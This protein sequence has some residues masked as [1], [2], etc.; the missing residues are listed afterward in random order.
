MV[1]PARH[2]GA[3]RRAQDPG[4]RRRRADVHRGP[5]APRARVAAGDLDAHETSV[6][7]GAAQAA[8]DTARPVEARL[9]AMQSPELWGVLG[10]HPLRELVSTEGPYPLY[11]DRTRALFG[12]W[13]EFFPRSEG[14]TKDAKTGT[15][16]TGTFRTA[17]EAPRRRGRHGLRRH[18]PAADPPDR[19]GQPQGP[20]QHP[21]PRPRGHRLAVGDRQQGRRPRRHPPRP[22]RLRRLRR[23]RRARR[24]ARPR[25]RA[26]PRA[27]GGARPPLGHQPP[28]VLHHPR[29]R[30]HRL[31]GEPAEEVP[32][33]LPGQLRQR[34]DRHLPRGAAHRAAV[35]VARRADLPRRQPAHQAAGVLGVAAQG[36]P[37]HRPG[38]ALPL[39]GVHPPG[40]DARP[41]RRSA[42]TRATPTS[43]GAPASASSRTTS[44]RSRPSPTT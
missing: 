16:T 36:D 4:R 38:R 33:H 18:L 21:H 37:P 30:L 39:R 3:R 8:G 13:Y 31:R 9:A 34:P 26:R 28:A 2:L 41:R 29:R 20:Q 19:R 27:P 22:R 15:V 35:D 24:R 43:R 14:A 1:R 42:T 11:A 44:P 10:A 5:P 40:D 12:S 23:L 7:G 17:A 25:G 6:V 32:G